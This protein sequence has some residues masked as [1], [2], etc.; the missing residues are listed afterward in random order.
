MLCACEAARQ[1][2]SLLRSCSSDAH[3][4]ISIGSRKGFAIA[5]C[6]P[7]G[8]VYAK[9]AST[10]RRGTDRAGEGPT[11][12]VEMLFCTSLVALVGSA[13]SSPRKLQI[14]NTKR[15]SLIC[16]LSFPTAVLGVRLNR[17]RLVVVLEEQIYVYD[18]SNLRLLHTIETSPNPNGPSQRFR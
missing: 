17:R 16:E 1:L 14:V 5:N 7:Y 11:A 18:I 12:I 3:S 6:E 4:C 10:L 15:G 9:S 8:K 13:N 2:V